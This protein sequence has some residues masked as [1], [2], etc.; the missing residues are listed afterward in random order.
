[1]LDPLAYTTSKFAVVG[2]TKALA[3]DHSHTGVR[4]NCICPGRVEAPFVRARLKEYADPEAAYGEMASTQLNDRMA[5]P[6]EMP[7]RPCVSPLM[8]ARWLR[9][10]L[11]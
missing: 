11:S 8:K 2:L 1:M 5:R 6:D 4:F 3:L 9:A 10:A 7:R